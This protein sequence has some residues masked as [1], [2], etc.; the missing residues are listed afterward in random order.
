MG[1]MIPQ[2]SF[3]AQMHIIRDVHFDVDKYKVGELYAIKYKTPNALTIDEKIVGK[4][5]KVERDALTFDIFERCSLESIPE[6]DMRNHYTIETLI[7]SIDLILRDRIE[8][9]RLL[10]ETEAAVYLTSVFVRESANDLF[11]AQLAWQKGPVGVDYFC[12]P[13]KYQGDTS[14]ESAKDIIPEPSNEKPA[15]AD[16]YKGDLSHL[17]L[18]NSSACGEKYLYTD[19]SLQYIGQDNKAAYKNDDAFDRFMKSE[20]ITVKIESE[21]AADTKVNKRYVT[22]FYGITN[23]ILINGHINVHAFELDSYPQFYYVYLK[24][25]ETTI[26]MRV[27]PS[28]MHFLNDRIIIGDRSCST[29]MV[30][31]V[32]TMC[33]MFDEIV[34]SDKQ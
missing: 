31:H 15:L 20:P 6:P 16:K 33:D 23:D 14:K 34:I 13:E 4:L 21:S 12:T 10:T 27:S 32:D 3:D 22:F 17:I 11:K 8:V 1:N 26:T 24:K 29:K 28:K 2:K 7:L 30:L 5:T 19:G 18:P 9:E 25:G